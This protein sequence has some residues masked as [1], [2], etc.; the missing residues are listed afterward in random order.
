MQ[1]P[2]SWFT[3]GLSE[4][5]KRELKLHDGCF[6]WYELCNGYP[7]YHVSS[8]Y[9]GTYQKGYTHDELV[10]ISSKEELEKMFI[11]HIK[12]HDIDPY[13]L[14]YTQHHIEDWDEEE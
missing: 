13:A 1:R 2:Y 4:W 12:K 11:R 6:M 14:I 10:D 7:I 5:N 3:K 9:K 8:I